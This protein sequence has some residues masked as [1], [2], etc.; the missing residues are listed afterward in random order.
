MKA[1][2]FGQIIIVMIGIPIVYVTVAHGTAYDKAGKGEANPGNFI[3]ALQ[4]VDRIK[5]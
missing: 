4:F 5:K 3:K 2:H 1:I